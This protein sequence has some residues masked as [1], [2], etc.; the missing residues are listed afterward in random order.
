M[1]F[2]RAFW[3][4]K[5]GVC[6][7]LGLYYL[8]ALHKGLPLYQVIWH[9]SS[10]C[11]FL[12]CSSPRPLHSVW[13]W[14]PSSLAP[15]L[16]RAIGGLGNDPPW[17]VFFLGSCLTS[18]FAPCSPSPGSLLRHGKWLLVSSWVCNHVSLCWDAQAAH[19]STPLSLPGVHPSLHWGKQSNLVSCPHWT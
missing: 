18:P 8:E 13:H 3:Q 11:L 17:C 6:I 1:G 10:S 12:L 19:C 7:A 16:P 14:E 15:L 4:G 2:T 9:S 5:D